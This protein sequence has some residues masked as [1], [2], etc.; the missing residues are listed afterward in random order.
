MDVKERNSLCWL[1]GVFSDGS[2]IHALGLGEG[3]VLGCAKG[4]TSRLNPCIQCQ[5]EKEVIFFFFL[6][7]IALLQAS[8]SCFLT[9]HITPPRFLLVLCSFMSFCW[10]WLGRCLHSWK[11]PDGKE[12]EH[13]VSVFILF[14]D[15]L[16]ICLGLKLFSGDSIFSKNILLPI[17]LCNP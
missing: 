14:S 10:F 15:Y 1:P 17:K 11:L 13:L 9:A 7:W 3:F 12:L 6:Q 8:H 4:S 2:Q 5:G 16:K